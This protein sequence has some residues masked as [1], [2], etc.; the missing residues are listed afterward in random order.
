LPA[1]EFEGL[2]IVV[3]PLIALM[4]D[5]IDQL[6]ARGHNAVRLDSSL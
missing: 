2:T 1:L 5:Q 4:K 6:H 3:S